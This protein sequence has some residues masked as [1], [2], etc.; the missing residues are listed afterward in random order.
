[1][2]VTCQYGLLNVVQPAPLL[3][4]SEQHIT[5]QI[6]VDHHLLA[7]KPLIF[8]SWITS[9]VPLSQHFPVI[10][11]GGAS[12]ITL[13]LTPLGTT[14]TS[15]TEA[16]LLLR[17]EVGCTVEF[18]MNALKRSFALKHTCLNSRGRCNTRT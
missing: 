5:I 4:D 6:K 12:G 9:L 10:Q 17:L 8:P 14:M 11:L 15:P 16:A 7:G 1:M 3:Q 2:E 18:T 13:A